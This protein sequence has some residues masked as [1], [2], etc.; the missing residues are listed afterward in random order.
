M[1]AL[2]DGLTRLASY[3]PLQALFSVTLGTAIGSNIINNWSTMMVSVSSLGTLAT[4]GNLDKLLVYGAIMGADLGPNI[5]ILGSLSSVL[6]LVL[7]RKRGLGLH[8]MW[9]VKLGLI[10]TPV[11]LIAGILPLYACARIWG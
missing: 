4:Q 1:Q 5:A 9:Y 10:V 7:L 11:L 3:G 2:A 6:W 8:P